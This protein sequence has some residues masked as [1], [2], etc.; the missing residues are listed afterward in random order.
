MTVGLALKIAGIICIAMSFWLETRKG[1]DKREVFWPPFCFVVGPG[2]N[3][4]FAGLICVLSA[5]AL[6]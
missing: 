3:W 6:K 1:A 4:A 5:W 2:A